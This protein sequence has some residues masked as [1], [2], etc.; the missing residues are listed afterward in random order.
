MPA[1]SDRV[2][3]LIASWLDPGHAERIA[4]DPDRIEL[5]YEPGLLPAPRYEADHHG[6]P[7]ALTDAERGRWRECLSRAEV[8]FEFD[9]ERPEELLRRAPR[10]RWVQATS[11]GIGPQVDRLGLA[12][13]PLVITNA[14]GIHA[15]G[16]VRRPGRAVL[17]E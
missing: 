16:R 2:P 13:A 11:S 14:A 12:G 7:R 10:L 9:W 1:A 15:A 3:V 5:M 17:R 4:A 8:M 6:P